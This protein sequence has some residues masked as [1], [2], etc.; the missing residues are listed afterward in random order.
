MDL[1]MTETKLPGVFV[2]GLQPRRACN[3]MA[4]LVL[5]VAQDQSCSRLVSNADIQRVSIS[6]FRGN[7]TA[8]PSRK[9]GKLGCS[10]QKLRSDVW[11][12]KWQWTQ[13]PES[14]PSCP[15]QPWS[16]PGLGAS[17]C[18]RRAPR[19]PVH[20]SRVMSLCLFPCDD[21]TAIPALGRTM[22]S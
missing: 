7:I 20:P 9:R 12:G 6:F 18:P 22:T 10:G 5:R 11:R 17:A 3:V 2:A 19:W 21:I 15:S 8:L 14:C 4:E 16:S 1:E 13:E